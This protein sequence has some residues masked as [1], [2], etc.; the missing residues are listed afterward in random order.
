MIVVPG[1]TL[2]D[3][4]PAVKTSADIFVSN[5]RTYPSVSE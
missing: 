2:N 1:G 5:G 4:N 3:I